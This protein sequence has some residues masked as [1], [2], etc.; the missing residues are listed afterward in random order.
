MYFS[1]ILSYFPHIEVSLLGFE[2]NLGIFT[3]LGIFFNIF[4]IYKL[5]KIYIFSNFNS[6]IGF[7]KN[8]SFWP[9]NWPFT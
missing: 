7:I 6:N 2:I 3:F 4:N 9:F 1:N 5:L 8:N